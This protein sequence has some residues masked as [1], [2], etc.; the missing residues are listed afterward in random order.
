MRVAFVGGHRWSADTGRVENRSVLVE[1]GRIVALDADPGTAVDRIVDVGDGLVVPGFIDAHVHPLKGGLRMLRCD[2]TDAASRA[3]AEARIVAAAAELPAGEWLLGGGWLYEWYESGN[4]SAE[5]LDRLAPDRPAVLEVRDGHSSWANSEALR[6]AGITADTPDPFDGRIERLADGA[7]QGTLHEG[8]MRLVQAHV[9][10]P[11]RTTLV[12][13]MRRGIEYLHAKG[14]TGWQD[15]WVTDVHH[16]AYREIVPAPDVVGALWW[17]RY[18]G[19]E[20][21]TEIV[22]TSKEDAG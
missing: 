11:D 6:R 8:A 5:H 22:A 9:P 15:A 7:P 2:L 3:E 18:R 12:R 21:I 20:Q 4:P 14:V 1:T 10:S 17:D 19:V 16:A 13:A